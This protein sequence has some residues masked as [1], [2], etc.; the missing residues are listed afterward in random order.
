MLE[1]CSCIRTAQHYTTPHKGS[2]LCASRLNKN[3]G[4][5][6]TKKLQFAG[7]G[8]QHSMKELQQL[9]VDSEVIP[10]RQATTL[11]LSKLLT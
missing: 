4:Y 8:I 10:N 3:Q 6:H 9:L 1:L 2:S 7:M 5:M 11:A